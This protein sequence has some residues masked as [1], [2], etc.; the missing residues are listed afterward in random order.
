M[1]T[2]ISGLG[3]VILL[4][5][6]WLFSPQKRLINWRL[7]G[8]GIVLQM[9]FA[10]F[11]FYIPA[12]SKLFVV[13][14]DV[15]V[16]IL[17]SATAGARF[18]FG[19]L[20]IPPGSKEESIGSI[21][22]F[23]SF[24]TII[25]FSALM[26]ILYYFNII[27]WIIRGFAYVFTKLM[28]ISGAESL[29]A[30][31][32]IF[33]G[34][35]SA[36]TIK[37]HLKEMTRSELF[38]VL[39]V[40]MSTVA[41]NVLAIYIFSLKEHFPMIGGH[42]ISASFISAPAALIMSKLVMPEKDVPATLGKD[43][44]PHYEKESNVFS[45]IINGA[46]SGVRLIVGI[47]ALLIAIISLVELIDLFLGWIGGFIG[48]NI[49]WSLRGLLGYVFYPFT[50]I[51]GIPIS[52]VDTISKIIGER[53]VVTE[54]TAYKD[55]AAAIAN[56][57]IQN[58]RTIVITTYALCGFAHVG[59]MAIFIGGIGALVPD[60]TNTL[61]KFGLRALV[62]ATLACLMTGCIAGLFASENTILMSGM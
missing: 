37:P 17:D 28:R 41:S 12:G 20:A 43:V 25:F 35:E 52:D 58:P 46:N 31:S 6:A 5:V 44:K 57:T 26:A 23:Q 9:I 7:I 13:L 36:F 32:N 53:M 10:V 15:V 8:W 14:N 4:I 42:L 29:S 21:L 2:A 22:A 62:A 16:K 1:Y 24:P 49:D 56:G 51:L 40:G 48:G 47:V 50:A 39:T 59:S 30:A 61:A 38:T 18:V 45:A 34:I 3:I 33:V 60:R 54:V 19:P 55:L 11:I 27:P